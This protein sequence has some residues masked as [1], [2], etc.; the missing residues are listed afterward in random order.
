MIKITLPGEPISKDRP[1]FSKIRKTNSKASDHELIESY[2]EHG[3]VWKVAEKFGM[4]GQSVHERLIRL[5]IRLKYPSI[6]EKEKQLI[7]E[8]YENGFK[9][10]SGELKR[11][12]QSLGRTIPLISR[13]A[14]EMGLTSK[15][16]KLCDSKLPE[17]SKRMKTW[18]SENDH[19]KG[20]LG[21]THSEDY[22]KEVGVRAKKKWA[23]YSEDQ[24]NEHVIKILKTRLK[25]H[26]TLC[27]QKGGPNVSWKQ[28]WRT[29]GGK[30]KYFRS[31]WEANYARYL[32]F[33]K[34]NNVIKEWLHEPETFWFDKIKRGC[35]S[36]LPDFKIIE[37]DGS[38]NWVE[39]KGYMCERSVTKLNRFKKYFPKEKLRVVD[40]KWFK[41]NNRKM[42]GL[43]IGWEKGKV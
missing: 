23:S 18:H 5:D 30:E 22:C 3:T 11:F 20:M 26:G 43:I 42:S 35:V 7:K 33:M 40:G 37:L 34:I 36:Y 21:K 15:N 16:R 17:I 6:T 8:F 31:R 29:I 32:E 19:P 9:I 13:T 14:K 39:V 41:E 1:R 25:N 4:C 12:A 38:H 28:G 2:L 10:G 24:R 27:P